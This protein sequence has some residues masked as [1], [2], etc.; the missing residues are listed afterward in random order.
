[1]RRLNLRSQLSEFARQLEEED[2]AAFDLWSWLPSH[3]AAKAAHGDYAA[4]YTPSAAD[5][6]KEAAIYLAALRG[7]SPA[8]AEVEQWFG[9]PCQ[10]CD[11][12]KGKL[13]PPLIK[14]GW[15]L[16][17]RDNLLGG[18]ENRGVKDPHFFDDRGDA[19][20]KLCGHEKSH[21]L[22]IPRNA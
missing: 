7:S 19:R 6:M 18:E 1:M 14:W 21:S 20:C 4:E 13:P 12:A 5:V 9:C 2:N 16:E 11:Q 22:H 17:K 3:K 15:E 8:P 10:E